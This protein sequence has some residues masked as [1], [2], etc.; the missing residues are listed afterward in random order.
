MAEPNPPYFSGWTPIEQPPE[1]IENITVTLDDVEMQAGCT[2]LILLGAEEG[3]LPGYALRLPVGDG[4]FT[5]EYID[6]MQSILV[7]GV[8]HWAP[9]PLPPGKAV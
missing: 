2:H 4:S 9:L 8:T 3:V 7:S 5:T 6:Y 1:P